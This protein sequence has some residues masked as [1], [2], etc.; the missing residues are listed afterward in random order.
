MGVHIEFDTKA[1]R[2]EFRKRVL[3]SKRTIAEVTNEVAFQI[4]KAWQRL[5]PVASRAAIEALGITY[6][7]HAKTGK[8]L[9]RKQAIYTPTSAFKLIALKSFWQRGPNPRS[10][11][12]AA[13][14]DAAIRKKLAKRNSSV[15]FVA[16]GPVPAMR[17]LIRKIHGGSMTGASNRSFK[18]TKGGATPASDASWN[19]FVEFENAT[20]LNVPGQSGASST[21]VEGA[22]TSTLGRAIEEVTEEMAEFADKEIEKAIHGD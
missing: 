19:P 21:R 8:L 6:R 22:L 5:I 17:A 3:R 1:F 2:E 12:N 15:G 11:A 7:T 13:E 9:K 16:S 20:G 18:G 14:L 10:F 4:L